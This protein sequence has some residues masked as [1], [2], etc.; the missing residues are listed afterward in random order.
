MNPANSRDPNHLHPA[1][2]TLFEK[3]DEEMNA[4]GIA[5]ILTSTYRS[6]AEQDR[7]YAQGRTA[8]GKRVTTLKGGQSKHNYELSGKPAAKAFDIVILDGKKANWD[9]KDPRWKQAGAIGR[10]V[11]LKWGGDWTRF[12]DYPHFEI[13]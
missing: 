5:F 3:F 10:K 1:L 13:A 7:L 12:K 9:V 8:P 4:A 2:Q 6:P 11:G